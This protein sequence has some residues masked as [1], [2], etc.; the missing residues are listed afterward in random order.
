[1]ESGNRTTMKPSDIGYIQDKVGSQISQPAAA[2]GGK[3]ELIVE[4]EKLASGAEKVT[5]M[6][7][8]EVVQHEGKTYA[9]DGN[10]RLLMFKVCTSRKLRCCCCGRHPIHNKILLKL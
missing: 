7:P 10:R 3:T 6:K 5:D 1:M 4:F 9:F 2:G 8:I